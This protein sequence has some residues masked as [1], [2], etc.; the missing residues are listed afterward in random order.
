MSPAATTTQRPERRCRGD[1]GGVS[2]F[3]MMILPALVGLAGLAYDGGQLFAERREAYNVAAAAARAGA[4]DLVEDS[5]YLG[6]PILAPSAPSTAVGFAY[7]QGVAT[8]TANP[9][10][11]KRLQVTVTNQVDMTFL[12]I[13]GIG[14]QTV[15]GTAESRVRDAVVGPTG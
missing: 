12:G 11:P 9:L 4:N 1:R 14:R 5:I 2:G 7:G 3:I 13:F 8:A 15:T 10:G 6:D